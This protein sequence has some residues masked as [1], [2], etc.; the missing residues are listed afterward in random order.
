MRKSSKELAHSEMTKLL[1][2]FLRDESGETYI[3]YIMLG[4]MLS[5]IAVSI[6]AR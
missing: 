4:A 5:V 1:R 3:E 6:F 2:S